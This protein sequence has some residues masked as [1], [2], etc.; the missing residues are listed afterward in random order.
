MPTYGYEC[1]ECGYRFE[2]MQSIK[3]DPLSVCPHCGKSALKRLLG[4]GGGIIFKGAGFYCN[5]YKNKGGKTAGTG[6]GSEK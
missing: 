6:E 3:A 4:T 1:R 2:K 5:D